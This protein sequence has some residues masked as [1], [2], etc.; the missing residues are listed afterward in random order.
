MGLETTSRRQKKKK[1]R[2][3]KKKLWEMKTVNQEEKI[4]EISIFQYSVSKQ[5]IIK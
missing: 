5:N 4:R 3:S 2:K 1:T